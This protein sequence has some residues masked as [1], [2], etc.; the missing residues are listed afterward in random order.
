MLALTVGQAKTFALLAVIVLI[1]LAAL[2]AWAMKE[3]TQKIVAIVIV[4]LVATLV[5]TQ[6]T[7]LDECADKVTAAGTGINDPTVDTTCTFFGRDI[8]V[9]TSRNST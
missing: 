5:W 3:L 4:G 7:A 1:A 2:F 8:Q 9:T 6:R